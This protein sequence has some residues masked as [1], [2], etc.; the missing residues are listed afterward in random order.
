MRVFPPKTVYWVNGITIE[1][2]PVH[3][4]GWMRR[5]DL[6][7]QSQEVWEAPDG[8]LNAYPPN[9]GEPIIRRCHLLSPVKKLL[10]NR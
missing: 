6:D 1:E 9:H 5:G 4:L 8:K 2:I 10:S 7:T 3:K